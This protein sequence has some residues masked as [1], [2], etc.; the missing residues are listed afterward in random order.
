MKKINIPMVFITTLCCSCSFNKYLEKPDDTNLTFWITQKVSVND[1]NDCT[2]LPGWM[3]ASEYLDG[4]YT[5]IDNDGFLTAPEIHVTYLVTGYPDLQDDTAITYIHITDPDIYVYGLTMNSSEE[6]IY[7]TMSSYK[8]KR[9]IEDNQIS[10][11]KNNVSLIIK[12][13]EI[14]IRAYTTNNKISLTKSYIIF[15]N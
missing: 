3:G 2:Y 15:S 9:S 8:F 13:N 6:E 10:Y 14:N 12:N 4:K 1:F 11:T 5:P 7:N